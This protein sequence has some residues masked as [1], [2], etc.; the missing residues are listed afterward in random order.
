MGERE[1]E[2]RVEGREGEK[3]GSGWENRMERGGK[4]GGRVSRREIKGSRILQVH[5]TLSQ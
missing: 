4:E 1:K 2:E 3:V 5:F